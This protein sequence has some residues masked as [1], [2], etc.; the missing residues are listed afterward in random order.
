MSQS[1][2]VSKWDVLSTAFLVGGTCIGGGMLGLPVGS[3]LAGFIPSSVLLFVC[4]FF[5]TLS[6]LLIL[7]VHL[8]MEEDSHVISMASK[9]LGRWGKA[10]AWL[11]YLFISYASII[12]YLSGGGSQV[13]SVFESAFGWPLEKWVAIIAFFLLFG[14][15]V[16]LGT[17][18]VGR[19]NAILFVAMIVAYLAMI[20]MG[21]SEINT[22]FLLFRSWKSS[23]ITIPLLLT[24]FS[25]QT[26]VPSLTPNLKGNA[27]LLRLSIVGGTTIALLVY[28]LWQAIVLGT[29]PMEGENGLKVAYERGEPATSF[30]RFAVQSKWL[31]SVAEFFAFFA[32][33]TSFLGITLGLFDFLS[34][35]LKIKKE[36]VGVLVLAALIVLPS[37]FFTLNYSRIF[38]VAME[39]SGGFGDSILNGI[40][41]VLMVWIGRYKRGLSS[42]YPC[43]GG[44]PLLII[45][46]LF[47][48]FVFFLEFAEQLGMGHVPIQ[49][50]D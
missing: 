26:I 24:A 6:G 32:L 23:L 20:F 30:L 9:F 8:W 13:A 48:F 4:W 22:S 10:V 44:K 12:A 31:S 2:E 43:P 3:C 33:V 18:V 25:F 28:L 40:M 49:T 19:V 11:L 14:P 27:R 16:F 50:L 7:E 29:I 37:L 34:D 47:Y 42:S 5:M 15:I 21:S 38:L 46:L 39:T 17:W 1:A 35:G 41:P 45:V 36:G